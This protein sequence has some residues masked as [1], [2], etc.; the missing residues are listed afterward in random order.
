MPIFIASVFLKKDKKKS[1]MTEYIDI[2]LSDLV[3]FITEVQY[4][5]QALK[6]AFY[7]NVRYYDKSDNSSV[8]C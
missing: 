4:N 5:S 7:I 3:C 6:L 2:A 1:Q 8:K